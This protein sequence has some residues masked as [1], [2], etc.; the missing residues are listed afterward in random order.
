MKL[1]VQIKEREPGSAVVVSLRGETES[2]T[3]PSLGQE[4]STEC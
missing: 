1:A 4:C 3:Y 2:E